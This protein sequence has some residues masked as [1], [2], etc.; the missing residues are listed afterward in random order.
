MSQQLIDLGAA[1]NDGTGDTLRE[2]AQK[3]NE[4]FT[5]VYQIASE[6][7]RITGIAVKLSNGFETWA[8]LDA[9]ED[10]TAA[11][12]RTFVFV[13]DT[14]T[15]ARRAGDV[16]LDLVAVPVGGQTL[17]AGV[18]ENIGGMM[19][20]VENLDA[21]Y[22]ARSAAAAQGS[23]N[24]I[25]P[26]RDAALLDISNARNTALVDLNNAGVLIVA[27]ATLQADRAK[28]E[29]ELAETLVNP[30]Y[31]ELLEAF[32]GFKAVTL[33]TGFLDEFT[34]DGQLQVRANWTVQPIFG[35]A[36]TWNSNL[37]T[38]G[39]K[40]GGV[41][42]SGSRA[43][44]YYSAGAGD[45]W[46]SRVLAV[47][48]GLNY[49]H[50]NQATQ[51]DA[52]RADFVSTTIGGITTGNYTVRKIV[53]GVITSVKQIGGM[54]VEPF[55]NIRHHF[56]AGVMTVYKNGRQYDTSFD[57]SAIGLTLTGRF[58]F[59]NA[60][61][62]AAVE[63]FKVVN[64][65]TQSAIMLYQPAK[66]IQ[67]EADGS[68]VL[69]LS[70]IYRNGSMPR[71]RYSIFDAATGVELVNHKRALTLNTVAA[72]PNQFEAQVFL[73]P[74]D[75]AA[76]TGGAAAG[77]IRTRVFR[78]GV[79]TAGGLLTS[80]YDDGPTQLFGD[81]VLMSGQSLGVNAGRQTVTAIV[82]A[83]PVGS[84][85]AN[86]E[87]NAVSTP[88]PLRRFLLPIS[89]NT[90]Q[91]ACV[92]ANGR[93][94][95]YGA[96]GIANT[97]IA[98]RGPGSNNYN[99]LVDCIKH[100]SAQRGVTFMIDGQSDIA[101]PAAYKAGQLAHA[102]ALR[103]IYPNHRIV[104][105][106]IAGQWA[107]LG[108]SNNFQTIRVVQWQLC[109]E[110]PDIFLWGP[111][112][113][114][115]QH[116]DSLH[117]KTETATTE[118]GNAEFNRRVAWFLRKLR[119][120]SAYDRSGPIWAGLQRVSATQVRGTF[121]LNG[122]DSLD[123]INSAV[124]GQFHGGMMFAASLAFTVPI[125][126]TAFALEAV[127]GTQQSVLW[128]F[129]ANSFPGTVFARCCWG[130][131]PFNPTNIAGVNTALQAQAN[132]LVGVKAGE[133]NVSVQPYFSGPTGVD[134]RSAA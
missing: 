116:L 66:V 118:L 54:R 92:A 91:A 48:T 104:F 127:V 80:F 68:A 11:G 13:S 37:A 103:T 43:L 12:D 95:G 98:T 52:L 15:H 132:M 29:R 101:D 21:Q 117:V 16:D 123:I 106:P 49:D 50:I 128:T 57:V 100:L 3:I 1:P 28:A 125:W 31:D 109:Q 25:V 134:Y 77:S 6:A 124:N 120:R 71:V 85:I 9:Y 70:G 122:F 99:A 73:S 5:E 112:M 69:F 26:A 65:A 86:G 24:A 38:N 61:P 45:R 110:Y 97:T 119:G 22:S 105:S 121:D 18:Y 74:A 78:D 115:L 83:A 67:L 47:T 42:A 39:G 7:Q 107:A 40:L 108:A 62:A 58:G 94:M 10:Q 53:A 81:T 126:P 131:N 33:L 36:N 17:N 8:D 102:Q 60:L 56:D 32:T 20:R 64:P 72:T 34:G 87:Y 93:P 82:N 63:S 41:P 88:D 113:M 14:G 19:I 114:D 4:N 96:N 79:L 51:N 129:P 84:Y 2:G 75:V 27:D 89:A 55:D 133:R 44:G 46:V 35:Q 30:A 23:L 59:D 90:N 111:H 130:D 76:L